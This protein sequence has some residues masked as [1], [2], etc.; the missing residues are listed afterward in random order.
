MTIEE[1]K[2]LEEGYIF[3]EMSIKLTSNIRFKHYSI[4]GKKKRTN[5]APKLSNKQ[6]KS[7]K[8]SKAGSK[9]RRKR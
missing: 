9:Q 4:N 8:K 1:T 5:I 6:I 2:E 7:R 3:T